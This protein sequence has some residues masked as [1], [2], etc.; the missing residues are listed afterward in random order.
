MIYPA[1][2][3]AIDTR[4][5]TAEATR[6]GYIRGLIEQVLFTVPGERVNRPKFGTPVSQLV[7]ESASP[8][9][10]ATLKFLVQGALE[11]WLGDIILVEQVEVTAEES[12]LTVVVRYMV[13]RTQEK[14]IAELRRGV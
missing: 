13:R 6:E 2:P 7:F 4:G 5:R 12:T 10:A 14:K 9:L 11:Q 8:E 3:Y 1:F